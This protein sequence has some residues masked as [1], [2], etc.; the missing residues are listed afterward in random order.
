L[1]QDEGR[2]FGNGNNPVLQAASAAYRVRRRIGTILAILLALVFGWHAIFGQNGVT[3]YAAKRE[4]DR[5]LTQQIETLKQ[6]NG[7]LQDHVDHLQT[8]PDTIEMEARQRLHYTRQ[9]EVIYTLNEKPKAQSSSQ[10][11]R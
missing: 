10:Q 1:P 11:G 4:E 9:G 5:A 7:K 3:A 8:D 2:M 6:E